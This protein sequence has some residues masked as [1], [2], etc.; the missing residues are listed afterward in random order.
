MHDK[1]LVSN[2]GAD[3]LSLDHKTISIDNADSMCFVRG[4]FH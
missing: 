4:H 1:V 2:V 3:V